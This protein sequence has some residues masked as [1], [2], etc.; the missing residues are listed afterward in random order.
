MNASLGAYANF[1][2]LLDLA[3]VAVP[4]G[5][6]GDGLP[7]GVTLV[8]PWG[9]DG[10]LAGFGARIHRATSTRI[11]ATNWPVPP[12]APRGIGVLHSSRRVRQRRRDPDRGRRRASCTGEPL[13]HELTSV[14]GKLLRAARTKPRYR[15]F[16]LAGD[17]AAETGSGANRRRKRSG[18]RRG[19]LGA[20]AIGLRRLCLANC[21]AVVHRQA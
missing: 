20:F 19:G 16:A 11:G 15:L 2:N 4:A 21:G 10:R 8:G 9:S 17:H 1:V 18:H 3:A 5:F 12:P 13:N 7:A 6:R 14:G